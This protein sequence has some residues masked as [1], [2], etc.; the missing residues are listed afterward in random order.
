M[1]GCKCVGGW[2]T[3][4]VV[5]GGRAGM[6]VTAYHKTHNIKALIE[7]FHRQAPDRGISHHY[8]D[9]RKAA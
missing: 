5:G 8:P 6:T 9:G 2:L 4:W 7:S 1:S 3:E